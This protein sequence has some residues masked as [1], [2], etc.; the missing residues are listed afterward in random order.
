MLETYT[1]SLTMVMEHCYKC[2]IPFGLSSDKRRQLIERGDS[3]WCPNGHQQHYCESDLVK[4]N[5]KIE[6]LQNSN[7]NLQGRCSDLSQAKNAAER[8]NSALRGVN[9][10]TKNR[11]KN[12]VCPCCNRHFHNLHKHMQNQ[13]P[14]Y[15]VVE[16]TSEK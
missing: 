11:I 5:K 15:G 14:E 8:S 2:G 12:G 13:H 16:G 9:T 7:T 6:R 1:D 10:R 3:F 4:A